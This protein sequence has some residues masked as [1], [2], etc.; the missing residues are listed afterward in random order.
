VRHLSVHRLNWCWSSPADSFLAPSSTGPMDS[1]SLQI[2]PGCRSA[3]IWQTGVIYGNWSHW[4]WWWRWRR[5]PKLWFLTEYWHVWSPEKI[6]AHVC[7]NNQSHNMYF[8]NSF[9]KMGDICIYIVR[10]GICQLLAWLT[11]RSWRWKRYVPPKRLYTFPGSH[12]TEEYTLC[13]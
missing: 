6:L 3:P 10:Y 4:P 13:I 12:T 5:F 9:Y 11:L 1:G 2:C 8:L 7:I